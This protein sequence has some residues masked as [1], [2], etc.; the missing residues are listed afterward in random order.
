MIAVTHSSLPSSGTDPVLFGITSI[1]STAHLLI[2]TS[3]QVSLSIQR[4]VYKQIHSVSFPFECIHMC[5]KSCMSLT[6]HFFPYVVGIHDVSSTFP[7]EFIIIQV[8]KESV[9][10]VTFTR[11]QTF[12]LSLSSSPHCICNCWSFPYDCWV[13]DCSCYCMHM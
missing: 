11:P 6:C 1:I 8:I 3:Y 9:Y 7:C 13:F 5:M 4:C 10:S 12:C 2:V